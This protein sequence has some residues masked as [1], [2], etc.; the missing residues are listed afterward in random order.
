MK[1]C[2]KCG[3]LKPLTDFHRNR[4][5]KDGH[6]FWCRACLNANAKA[7]RLRKLEHY[8]AKNRAWNNSHKDKIKGYFAA[9][10]AR[11]RDEAARRA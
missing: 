8:R 9:F 3:E 6:A 7:C 4:N 1:A 5:E 11:K 2:T 10:H